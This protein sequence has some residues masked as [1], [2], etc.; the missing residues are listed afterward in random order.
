MKKPTWNGFLGF[1][2]FLRFFIVNHLVDLEYFK[3]LLKYESCAK[4]LFF[5]AIYID[6]IGRKKNK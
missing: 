4:R 5:F 2:F 1:V 6:K 3:A